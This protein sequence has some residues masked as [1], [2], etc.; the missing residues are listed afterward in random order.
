MG[1]EDVTAYFHC[2]L[3]ESAGANPLA[4]E[5]M[6]TANQ[7]QADK[8]LDVN[9]IMGVAAIPSDFDRVASIRASDDRKSIILTSTASHEVQ[10]PVDLE[11]LF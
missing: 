6:P 4:K 10:V 8:P 2:G 9:Y 11:W 1:I 3:A 7:L 5:G